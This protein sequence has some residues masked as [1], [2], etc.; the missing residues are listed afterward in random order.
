MEYPR[1]LN[2][3]RIFCQDNRRGKWITTVHGTWNYI[4]HKKVNPKLQ[5]RTNLG[6]KPKRMHKDNR[7]RGAGGE[8]KLQG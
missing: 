6:S 8:Y 2:F 5:M 7:N 4:L 1:K 3:S